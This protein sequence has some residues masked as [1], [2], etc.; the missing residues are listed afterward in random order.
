MAQPLIRPRL[1]RLRVSRLMRAA[2][3]PRPGESDQPHGLPDPQ[4]RVLRFALLPQPR[5]QSGR[6]PAPLRQVQQPQRSRPQLHP[7]SDR[8]G[9]SGPAFRLCGG[10]ETAEGNSEQGSAG[11]ARPPLPQQG[12]ARVCY[13]HSDHREHRHFRLAA[14][15]QTSGARPVA[16]RAGVRNSRPVRGLLRRMKAHLTRRYWFSASHRLH[17]DAMSPEENQRTY[18]K[19]NNP[20]GHGHNYALEV[21][22]SGPV[23]Q[24]TGMVCNLVELDDFVHAQI[25]ERF[26][27]ENLNTLAAF[28]KRVPTTENLCR[29]IFEILQRGFTA[30]HL[31]KVRLEETM[32]NSFEYAGDAEVRK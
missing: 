28:R 16:S 1:A 11:C 14:P 25:L 12:S 6:K 13:A 22:V 4:S 3:T 27:H 21:T 20:H 5:I 24:A 2:A 8:Q 26:G 9:R 19:C 32:M 7:G 30:A 10:F 17:S 18:G 29:E 23:D 31:D 15:A